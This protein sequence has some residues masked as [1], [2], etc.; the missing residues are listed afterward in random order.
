MNRVAEYSLSM[1]WTIVVFASAIV[2]AGITR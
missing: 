2:S 1:L